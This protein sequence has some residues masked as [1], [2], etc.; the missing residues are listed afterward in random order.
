[1]FLILKIFNFAAKSR[2]AIDIAY[3]LKALQEN[4]VIVSTKSPRYKAKTPSK[5]EE[6]PGI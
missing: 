6:K 2:N 5:L 4:C 3:M 1:M